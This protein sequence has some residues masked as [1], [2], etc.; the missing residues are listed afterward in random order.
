MAGASASLVVAFVLVALATAVLAVA[1]VRRAHVGADGHLDTGRSVFYAFVSVGCWM[2][3]TAALAV[4]G[5]LSDFER[6]PPTLPILVVVTFAIA[7]AIAF[8][9]FGTR[10]IDGLP[11]AWLI[12]FQ[13]FRFP[14]EMVMHRAAV[15][16]VMPIQM[17]YSGRNLDIM[18]GVTALLVAWLIARGHGTRRTPWLWNI[19]GSA[20]LLNIVVVAILSLPIFAAWGPERVNVWISHAPF[21]W[22]PTVLVPFALIGHLLLWRKLLRG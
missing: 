13:G 17:S 21:V 19:L 11:L 8:S 12:G 14:L 15:E 4:S 16:G 2:A 1:L 20:L 7:V 22:L 5:V 18:S 9:R 3:F 10:I 6:R